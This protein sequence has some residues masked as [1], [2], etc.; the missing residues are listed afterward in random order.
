MEQ[1]LDKNLLK[2]VVIE[3]PSMVSEFK[4]DSIKTS[5][6]FTLALLK[7]RIPSECFEKSVLTSLLYMVLDLVLLSTA[8]FTYDYLSTTWL[9]LIFY[10]NIYGFL[11]WCLFVVGLVITHIFF[12]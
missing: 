1:F 10:W 6:S 8:F 4:N 12:G 7:R 11:M 2:E 9:G 3:N 5:S